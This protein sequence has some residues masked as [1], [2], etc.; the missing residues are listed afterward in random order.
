MHVSSSMKEPNE[1]YSARFSFTPH[2]CVFTV[3]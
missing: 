3:Y 1:N 2:H